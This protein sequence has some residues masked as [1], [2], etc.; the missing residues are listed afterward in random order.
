MDKKYIDENE[1]KIKYLRNQLNDREL[2][3]FEIYMLENPDL[4]DELNLS[5][6]FIRNISSVSDS[7]PTIAEPQ[8]DSGGNHFL[9][10][11]RGVATNFLFRGVLVLSL[12]LFGIYTLKPVEIVGVYEFYQPRGDS[13]D[14]NVKQIAVP[15]KY[16][17]L[18]ST[19]ELHMVFDT[20]LLGEREYVVEVSRGESVDSREFSLQKSFRLSSNEDGEVLLKL[21]A[22]KFG[23]GVFSVVLKEVSTG[24]LTTYY[25]NSRV[26]ENGG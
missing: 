16:I 21:G 25:F 23:S 12:G 19:A 13:L 15:P 2:E 9:Q 17:S 14:V 5:E 6:V 1:I 3:L 26:L 7:K 22:K 24:T 4:V 8:L 11:L 20:S 18:I 10:T